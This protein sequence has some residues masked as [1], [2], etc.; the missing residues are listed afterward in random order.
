MTRPTS[1][2]TVGLYGLYVLIPVHH[3]GK[4]VRA[5]TEGG[6]WRSGGRGRGGVLL[7]GLLPLACSACSLIEPRTTSLDGT[8]HNEPG[9][10]ISIIN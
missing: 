5:G 10:L 6:T 9:A 4:E 3:E 2:G 7:T 8:T 1:E